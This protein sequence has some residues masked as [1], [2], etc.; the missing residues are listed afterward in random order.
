MEILRI[1]NIK[2][3]YYVIQEIFKAIALIGFFFW[4]LHYVAQTFNVPVFPKSVVELLLL[5]TLS[6]FLFLSWLL[7]ERK[8]SLLVTAYLVT[9]QIVGLAFIFKDPFVVPRILIPV[10][11]TYLS[12]F[13]FQS[14]EEFQKLAEKQKMEAL[15]KDLNLLMERLDFY[16]KQLQEVEENYKKLL[17]EKQKLEELYNSEASTELEELLNEKER[18]LKEAEE[19]IKTLNQ[20]IEQL[21]ENNRE[22][23]KLLEESMEE[24]EPTKGK[25][26]LRRL[27]KERKKLLK[28]VRELE[29]LLNDVKMTNELLTLENEELKKRIKELEKKVKELEESLS[30]KKAEL[31]R[32]VDLYER[33]LGAYINLLLERVYLTPSAL[34]DFAGL[35]QKVRKNFVKYLK[36][37]ERLNPSE[38]RFESLETSKGNIFKDRFSGGRVYLTIRDG[39]FVI[40]GIL[41]GED[42]KKKDRFIRERFA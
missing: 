1:K 40:E 13:L 22:L 29:G 5:Y 3:K 41:E 19:K 4:G 14:P 10:L 31:E 26:E 39:K 23:W 36:K 18:A 30:R 33:D 17:E 11:L 38:V 7:G 8:K 27:R 20:K 28:R 16:K 35:S 6:G 32:F 34:A 2:Y 24:E 12:L 15:K 37:L 21:K 25:E 9:F 42:S